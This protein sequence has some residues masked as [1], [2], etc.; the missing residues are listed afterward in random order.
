MKRQI[1][2]TTVLVLLSVIALVVIV[3][4]AF[5]WRLS[6]GPVSLNFLG[7]RI[8]TAINRQ[9]PGF[10]VSL[11]G[12]ILELDKVSSVPRIR[13]RDLV[14]RDQDNNIIATAARAA[15]DLDTGELLTGTIVARSLELI[16]PRVSVKRKLDGGF[17]LG[18]AVNPNTVNEIIVLEDLSARGDS[19][20]SDIDEQGQVDQI[21]VSDPSS[22]KFLELI[23]NSDEQNSIS[24][25]ETIRITQAELSIYDEAN[26]A[27]WL[28]PN[29][30]LTF[31]RMPY[32]F[33]VFGKASIATSAAP[34]N[35][36]ISATYRRQTKSF[37]VSTRIENFIPS[38]VADKIYALGQLARMD[39]ALSGQAEFEVSATGDLVTGTAELAAGAGVLGLPDYIAQPLKIDQGSLRIA[40]D[41]TAQNFKLTDSLFIIGG[42]KSELTGAVG[43]VREADGRISAISIDLKAQN[44]D[45]KTDDKDIVR[46]DRIEFVGKAAVEEAKLV[47]DDLVVMSGDAGVRLRGIIS[48]GEESAGINLAGRLRDVS[49]DLLKKL[50]P[51]IITP[52]TRD[53]VQNNIISGRITDGTFTVN[54]KENELAKSKEKR[55]LANDT[56]DFKF[57]L[58]NVSSRYFKDLPELT[59]AA[60]VG[61]LQGNKFEL[62]I[63]KGK[64]T[65]ENGKIITL[66]TGL[67]LVDGLLNEVV[68][69]VFSFDV[70][71]DIQSL[72]SYANLPALNLLKG[73]AEKASR[74]S[75]QGNAVIG[76]KFPL[77]KNVP[78]ERVIVTTKLKLT[79]A[80]VANVAPGISL[81]DGDFDVEIAK[82]GVV[83]KGPAKLNGVSA[84]VQW[85]KTSGANSKQ[86]AVVNAVLDEKGRA[87]LNLRLSE[88]MSGSVPVTATFENLETAGSAF[89]VDAD[90]SEVSLRLKAMSYNRPATAKTK[91]TFTVAP[92]T[93]GGVIVE[94]FVVTGD[95]LTLR[96]DLEIAKGGA[97]RVVNLK[98][99]SLDEETSF[100]VR[101]EPRD[102]GYDVS[103]TGKTFD[104]RPYIKA[105][106]SPSAKP[107]GGTGSKSTG[108]AKL[109]V[110]ARFDKVY[111]FR[112]EIVQDLT[113]ALDTRGG[114]IVS[115]DINGKFLSGQSV[116]VR[117]NPNADGRELRIISTDAGAV[118]R[119]S[120]FYAKVAGGQFELIANLA[121]D[122]TS[123]LR[124]GRLNLRNFDVRNEAALAELDDRGRAKKSGPRKSGL[125][126]KRLNLPFTSDAKFIR[127]GDTLLR[128]NDLG[129]TASGIIR[130]SDGAV[131]ITG[132]FIPAYAIN[133]AIGEIPLIGDILTGGNNEGIFGVTFAMSGTTAKPKF[134]M[135]PISA[136]APGILRKF[137]EFSN[138][139]GAPSQFDKRRTSTD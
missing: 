26:D 136:L 128:G 21:A 125:S 69:G 134:Q 123:S 103:L 113:A 14:L 131:D 111:T 94:D 11:G 106:T 85:S 137:F 47:I 48:G 23:T 58:A 99:V 108:K 54:L 46:I 119:A 76:L 67:I 84:K 61:H 12:A 89:K 72:L 80:A 45:P 79:D 4:A 40:Y 139:G 129:A 110:N 120:N 95:N 35:A 28:A 27:N 24:T 78:K 34:W 17:N 15:V 75:G 5:Y 86:T 32:G 41:P 117:I 118:L 115:A 38:S 57:N 114:T 25:L 98:Q 6:Q 42:T 37:S 124:D 127:I 30:D 29:T 112:G 93:K 20:K 87:A 104:A 3:G 19:G 10:Q 8:E 82:T 33:V 13:F 43:P 92:Q 9:I 96:G 53:W 44:V 60:G 2:K 66:N 51:P 122:A 102:G 18:I 135:N 71:S 90:L 133:S 97:L 49:S 130:K 22:A 36:E 65:L 63:D 52:K 56:I 55:F 77:I 132:T 83:V 1:G 73:D 31:R 91:A 50:W 121:N 105:L 126:F 101:V 16:G 100:A 62:K 68:P 64:V 107:S 81:T 138:G 39:I 59:N 70:S 116:A 74:V 88:F 109:I 7:N